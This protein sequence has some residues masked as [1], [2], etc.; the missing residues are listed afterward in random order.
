MS[1]KSWYL[2]LNR[3]YLECST[4]QP[5]HLLRDVHV[6]AHTHILGRFCHSGKHSWKPSLGMARRPVVRW[7]WMSSTVPKRWPR[8]PNFSRGN[9]QK[10]Q[11]TKSG[12]QGGCGETAMLFCAKNSSTVMAVWLGALSWCKI[13]PP[14]HFSGRF[15]L[16]LSRKSASTCK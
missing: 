6:R 3:I 1:K 10:S 9:S 12:E 13:H 8:S 16:T 15:I 4:Q 2:A 14:R 11:G 5:N 7:R